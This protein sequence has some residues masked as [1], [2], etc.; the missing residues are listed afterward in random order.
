MR[1]IDASIAIKLINTQEEGSSSA[2][3]LLLAHIKGQEKIIVPSLLFIEVANALATKSLVKEDFIKQGIHLLYEANF[4]VFEINQKM[5]TESAALAKEYGTSVY[6][7]V[8]AV[9]AK[10]KNIHLITADKKFAK[11]VNFKFIEVLSN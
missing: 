5:L 6:D 2:F 1:I 3:N 9:I 4:I 8:Y 10:N 11:K 7:M